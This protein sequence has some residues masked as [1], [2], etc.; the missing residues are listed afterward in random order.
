M[1]HHKGHIPACM[2]QRAS[3]QQRPPAS[4]FLRFFV[5]TAREFHAIHYLCLCVSKWNGKRNEAAGPKM[6][7]VPRMPAHSHR[8][9]LRNFK[10]VRERQTRARLFLFIILCEIFARFCWLA[11]LCSVCLSVCLSLTSG[12]SGRCGRNKDAAE[13]KSSVCLKLCAKVCRRNT[14]GILMKA[15]RNIVWKKCGF[16]VKTKWY[17]LFLVKLFYNSISPKLS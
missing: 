16:I 2:Q 17:T 3:H 11:L 13:P 15:I 1:K 12:W 8:L 14:I 6:G 7:H 10:R 5:F 9:T 4:G